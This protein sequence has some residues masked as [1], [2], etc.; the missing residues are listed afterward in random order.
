[1]NKKH[2]RV[3]KVLICDLAGEQCQDT[4]PY[5]SS[6]NPKCEDCDIFQKCKELIKKDA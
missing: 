1:M 2:Y 6:W 4:Q 3:M 5:N